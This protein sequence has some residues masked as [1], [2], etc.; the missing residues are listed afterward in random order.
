V[1][2]LTRV[3]QIQHRAGYQE[4]GPGGCDLTHRTRCAVRSA[5]HRTGA[6]T[7]GRHGGE[8]SFRMRPAVPIA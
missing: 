5:P 8:R 7:P 3:D 4:T 2:W 1:F 6:A